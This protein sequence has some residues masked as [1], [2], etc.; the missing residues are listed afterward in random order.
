MCGIAVTLHGDL[1]KGGFDVAEIARSQLDVGSFDV[2]VEAVQLGGAGDGDDPGLLG[3]EPRE[4]DLGRGGMFAG[5]DLAEE[6]DE[7]L[8]G[9]AGLGGKARDDV[10]EVGAGEGGVL[11]DRAGEEAPTQ[12]TERGRSRCPYRSCKAS[13]APELRVP[14]TRG[15]TRSEGP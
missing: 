14:A 8:I 4:C 2:F 9:L 10:A 5:G 7:R 11:A 12:G 3:E 13:E 15:N 1:R 6:V